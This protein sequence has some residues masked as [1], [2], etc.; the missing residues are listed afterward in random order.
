MEV[1]IPSGHIWI[2]G[3]NKSQSRDSRDFGPLS[4]CF[5]EGIVRY[6]VWPIREKLD[7]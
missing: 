7:L 2:E 5:V 3:D 6:K 1:I 4:V